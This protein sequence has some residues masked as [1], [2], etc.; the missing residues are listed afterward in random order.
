[1]R[2]ATDVPYLHCETAASLERPTDFFQPGQTVLMM[3]SDANQ[4]STQNKMSKTTRFFIGDTAVGVA[5][6][7]LRGCESNP[8]EFVITLGQSVYL[9]PGRGVRKLRNKNVYFFNCYL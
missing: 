8:S 4:V 2:K 6:E 3:E 1:M 9:V 5:R 7:N